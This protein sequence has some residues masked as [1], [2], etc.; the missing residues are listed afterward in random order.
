M[1]TLLIL[2]CLVVSCAM[3]SAHSESDFSVDRPNTVVPYDDHFKMVYE[4]VAT[5]DD[6]T[7]ETKQIQVMSVNHK[8]KDTQG[9]DCTNDIIGTA[10]RE[11]IHF[12]AGS[13]LDDDGNYVA[14]PPSIDYIDSTNYTEWPYTP[15]PL[16]YFYQY[17][18]RE[19]AETI[20]NNRE[21][22]LSGGGW[23]KTVSQQ[24]YN[25]SSHVR[26]KAFSG[27]KGI[28]GSQVL[29]E[30]Y[31]GAWHD[32]NQP[33]IGLDLHRLPNSA[34]R[35]GGDTLH[36]DPTFSEGGDNGTLYLV[37][38]AGTE[39]DVTPS[40]DDDTNYVFDLMDMAYPLD[41]GLT[42][43]MTNVNLTFCKPEVC[44]GQ[45]IHFETGWDTPP[46]NIVNVPYVLWL[47]P[48]MFVND[49]YE[50]SDTCLTYRKI[51]DLLTNWSTSCWYVRDI[52]NAIATIKAK[53]QMSNG[54]QL[55]IQSSGEF[56]V[57][58]PH[59]TVKQIH[60]PRYYTI[61]DKFGFFPGTCKLKLGMND[62]SGDGEMF[63]ELYVY[64]K[65][66]NSHPLFSG[67][68]NI[69]QLITAHYSNPIAVFS[70]ERCDGPEL[71]NDGGGRVVNVGTLGFSDGPSLHWTTPD[72]VSLSC[73]DFVRFKPDGDDSIWVTLGIVSWHTNGRADQDILS[74]WTITDDSTPDPSDPDDSDEFPKW[75]KTYKLNSK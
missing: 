44:V 41:I 42:T 14:N 48:G 16:S 11:Q 57:F 5:D 65:P 68:A 17:E 7:D 25:Y 35:V 55:Q 67:D 75:T 66:V 13:G 26:L 73:R 63:Y 56:S 15:T 18:S 61:D 34:V 71:Y 54:Q 36:D 21:F 45:M 74:I 28:V 33:W 46:P 31:G 51:P 40:V 24:T 39:T 43:V 10:F 69:T 1:K 2:S 8:W 64:S 30:L 59:V 58:R 62:E 6:W 53:L 60:G 4:S 70:D 12:Q 3:A 52:P 50:Y 27:G 22:A 32:N 49:W 19:G 9:H 29:H 37:A 23:R 20:P 72:I 47:L 38:D